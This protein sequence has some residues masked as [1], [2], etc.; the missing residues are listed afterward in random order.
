MAIAKLIQPVG[1]HLDNV[2]IKLNLALINT[3]K[4]NFL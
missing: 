2:L 4:G 1:P 3:L